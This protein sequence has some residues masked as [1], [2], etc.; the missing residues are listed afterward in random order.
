[1][2]NDFYMLVKKEY[3]KDGSGKMEPACR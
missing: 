2:E 1:L 3:W